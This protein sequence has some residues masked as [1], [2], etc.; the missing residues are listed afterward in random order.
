MMKDNNHPGKFELTSIP[1]EPFGFP[2]ILKTFY[3]DAN[4]ISNVFAVDK[5]SGK[6]KIKR[7]MT[8]CLPMETLSIWSKRHKSTKLENKKQSFS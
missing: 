2:Q 7:Q 5:R 6:K 1:P 8:Q 4:S 3:I